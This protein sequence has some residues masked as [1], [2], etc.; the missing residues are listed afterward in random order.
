MYSGPHAMTIVHRQC[1][2]SNVAGLQPS[3]VVPSAVLQLCFNAHS[4][5]APPPIA[6]SLCESSAAA[7][8]AKPMAV[9]RMQ[10]TCAW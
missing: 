8:G 7:H 5:G 3:N 10:V 1:E 2:A 6:Y 4:C 9:L